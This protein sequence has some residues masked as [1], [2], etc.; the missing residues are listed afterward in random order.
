MRVLL[1][2]FWDNVSKILSFSFIFS[3]SA[4]PLFFERDATPPAKRPGSPSPFFQLPGRQHIIAAE[5]K[6][7]KAQVSTLNR[8]G[9]GFSGGGG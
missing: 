7:L 6:G 9:I 3:A 2:L 1:F 4:S 5:S 8:V